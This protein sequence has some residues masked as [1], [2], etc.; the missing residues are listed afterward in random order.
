MMIPTLRNSITVAG[1]FTIFCASQ[2]H[3][4]TPD[5]STTTK[6]I[7]KLST[8]PVVSTN[9]IAV[10]DNDPRANVYQNINSFGAIGDGTTDNS[11][12]LQNA[13]NAGYAVIVPSG[14]F[15]FSTTLTLKKDSII[16]GTGKKSVLQYT[17]LGVALREAVGSFT[18]GYDN[19]KLMN[20]TLSTNNHATTGI[21]LTNT[22]QVT[23]QGLYVDGT[24][25][26]FSTAGI[27][28]SAAGAPAGAC[29]TG[30]LYSRTDGGVNSTLY[31]CQAGAWTAK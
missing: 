19:L 30:S 18:G 29:T 10:G 3:A 26:G 6:G 20:F 7:T 31:V 5:A 17:G 4:Q 28:V 25:N 21:E 12:A 1:L 2:V 11:T 16:V 14:T 27:H 15:N 8:A 23:I 24:T 9:P 13:I 22:Y